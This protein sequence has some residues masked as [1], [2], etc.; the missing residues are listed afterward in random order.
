MFKHTAKI[1]FFRKVCTESVLLQE[2][3]CG[4]MFCCFLVVSW[5]SGNNSLRLQ[6]LQ[7]RAE[8]RKSGL[9]MN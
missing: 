9:L 5:L 6:P 7:L 4:Q 1:F 8:R 3:F 2:V